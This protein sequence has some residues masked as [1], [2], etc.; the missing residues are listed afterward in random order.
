MTTEEELREHIDQMCSAMDDG[1]EGGQSNWLGVLACIASACLVFW[2]CWKLW[3]W[4][5]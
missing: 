1:S 4:F 3:N 5:H 2:G